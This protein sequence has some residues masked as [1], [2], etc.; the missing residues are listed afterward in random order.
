MYFNYNRNI[1][2]CYSIKRIKRKV[3]RKLISDKTK[4]I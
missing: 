4:K 1:N 3:E 2:I